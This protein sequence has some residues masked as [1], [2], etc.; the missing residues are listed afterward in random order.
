MENKR[1]K[2]LHPHIYGEK[3]SNKSWRPDRYP[4][5]GCEFDSES[6]R[7]KKC[8]KHEGEKK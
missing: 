7:V 4:F 3:M 1:N 5:C 2:I 8:E 6:N